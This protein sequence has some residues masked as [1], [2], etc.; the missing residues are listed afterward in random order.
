M[1]IA[2]LR[3]SAERRG[4]RYRTSLTP[5]RKHLE[6][7][8]N[9]SCPPSWW[10]VKAYRQAKL[11]PDSANAYLIK[12]RA[13]KQGQRRWQCEASGTD[14]YGDDGVIFVIM[15][16][17]GCGKTTVGAALAERLGAAFIE[18]D[19]FHP[20]SN[21]AKMTAGEPLSDADRWPWLDLISD[22]LTR[23]RQSAETVVLACSALKRSYRDRLRGADP[24]LSFILL[25]GSRE[26]LQA[27]LDARKH[28]FMPSTLLESQLQALEMPD[29]DE[30][31]LLLNVNEKPSDMVERIVMELVANTV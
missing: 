29:S 3:Q 8:I 26:L 14:E 11:K 6:G 19:D 10:V 5:V 30:S 18:G 4:L 13:A 1:P 15:G 9:S 23:R 24:E 16:P 20:S 25:N 7:M 22:E 21:R 31:A 17:C 27:R 2:S 12:S 28:H